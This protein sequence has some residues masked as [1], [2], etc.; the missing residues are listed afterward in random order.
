MNKE[1]YLE[2]ENKFRGSSEIISDRLSMYDQLL[3]RIL[4]QDI[5]YKTIDIGCGRGE[6]LKKMQNKVSESIGIES[7]KEMVEKCKKLGFNVIEGDAIDILSNFSESSIDLITIFHV[8]EHLEN[9]KLYKLINLCQHVLKENGVLIIETPSIDNIL[10]STNSFYLD[11]THVN[12]INP[13]FI[14]FLLEKTG[15]NKSKYYFINGGPLQL[16]E[17]TKITRILNG[18]AQDLLLVASNSKDMTEILFTNSDEWESKLFLAPN[19]LQSATEYDLEVESLIQEQDQTRK[20]SESLFEQLF[21]QQ[22]QTRKKS[23]SLFEQQDQTRKKSES[24][25]EQLFEQQDQIR[26]KSKSFRKK[27]ESLFEQQDQ[28]RKKSESL[29]EQLFEQQD[30]IRKKSKSFRKKSE[31]LFEQQDQM[32]IKLEEE[33]MIVKND[34]LNC[35]NDLYHLRNELKYTILFERMLRKLLKPIKVIL[36][37]LLLKPIKAILLNLLMRPIKSILRKFKKYFIYSAHKLFNLLTS[38]EFI[39]RVLITK[40]FRY[41]LY[42]IFEKMLREK[43]INKAQIDSKF[44]QF[45]PQKEE[46]NKFNRRL[47]MLYNYSPRSKKFSKLLLDI[48][49]KKR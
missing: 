25:F 44:Y 7:D 21:E 45:S 32:R 40:K 39:R 6:W 4:K 27:S 47:T 26:K 30:Q 22:D 2:F 11:P 43:L 1:F 46:Y 31:S 24:L 49:N 37:N 28:T 29:F 34:I 36:L 41:M 38:I 8:V 23:E 33:N 15:F 19:T 35:R 12:H 5:S 18:V 17:S 42:L 9:H 3:N 20:K 16:A 13:D 14:S 10:V 48:K